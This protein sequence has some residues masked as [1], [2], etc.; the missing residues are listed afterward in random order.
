MHLQLRKK[1]RRGFTLVEILIVVIV[2][3]ILAGITIPQF[4]STSQDSR[5]AA[6][7]SQLQTV[8]SAIEVYRMQHMDQ[9]PDLAASWTPLLTQTN[10]QGGTT[11]TTLVGPYLPIVPINAITGGSTLSTTAHAGGDWVWT[12]TTG[13]LQALDLQGNLF[14]E[15]P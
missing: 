1:N 12:P 14:N 13:Q 9:L 7:K 3:G 6:L 4:G 8:R 10:P 5:N 15:S 2:L 11:G